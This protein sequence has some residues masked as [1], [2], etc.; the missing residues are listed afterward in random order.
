MDSCKVGDK[1][2]PLRQPKD[3]KF[4]LDHAVTNN[5]N[6]FCIW[7]HISI[8]SFLPEFDP[9]GH[10]TKGSTCRPTRSTTTTINTRQNSSVNGNNNSTPKFQKAIVDLTRGSLK[11]LIIN[12]AT[13]EPFNT[14]ALPTNVQL[15]HNKH[16]SQQQADCQE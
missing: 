15:R 11:T 8:M 2:L 13:Q 14:N 10:C 7:M 5:V 6:V 3:F 9:F 16:S 4:V 1:C 12:S